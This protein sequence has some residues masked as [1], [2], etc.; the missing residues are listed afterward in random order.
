MFESIYLKNA[1]EKEADSIWKILQQA[2]ERRKKDGSLQWQ[3]GYPNPETIKEDIKK[4]QAFVL[5]TEKQMIGV[6][7]LI[8][9]TEPAYQNIEGKWLS[10]G[11]FLVVHRVAIA[12]EFLGKGWSKVLFEKIEKKALSENIFSIKADTNFDNLPMISTFKSMGFEYCG[13]VMMRNSPRK[14]FEKIL[15]K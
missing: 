9:N 5:I 10:E 1:S 6:C 7:T 11:D 13:E 8:K 3:D 15:R 4:K 12:D 2:I 14:A